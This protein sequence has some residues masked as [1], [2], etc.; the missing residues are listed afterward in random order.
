MQFEK[1]GVS[2]RCL[3]KRSKMTCFNR[4]HSV[5]HIAFAKTKSNW[6]A[7]LKNFVT[8]SDYKFVIKVGYKSGR[9]KWSTILT[10]N[11]SKV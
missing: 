5:A 11:L 9:A 7:V 10:L 6:Q 8:N 3:L 2:D 4:I 1:K